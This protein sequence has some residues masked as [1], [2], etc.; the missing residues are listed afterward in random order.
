MNMPRAIY[1]DD[2]NYTQIYNDIDALSHRF[3]QQINS[4]PAICT[5]IEMHNVSVE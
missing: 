2:S 4:T 1:G 3:S 5:N